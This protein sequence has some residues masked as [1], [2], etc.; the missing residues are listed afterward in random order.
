MDIEK[1]VEETP[2]NYELGEKVRQLY[3]AEKNAQLAHLEDVKDKF[4]FESPDGGK[5]VTKRPFGS[6]IS[7]R[8]TIS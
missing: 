1:L 6:D 8:V 7:E 4:I 2:N 3:W 5:T